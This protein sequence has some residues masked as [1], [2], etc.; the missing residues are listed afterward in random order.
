MDSIRDCL[1]LGPATS[2]QIQAATNL[3]QTAVS[4]RLRS[5][6]SSVV[7][8]KNG[9][10]PRYAMTRSA[11]GGSD[12]LPLYMVDAHGNNA[13]VA[14][15]RP[16]AHR[17]FLLEGLTGM[18]PVLLGDNGSGIFSNLPYFLYDLVPQGYIGRQIASELASQSDDFPKDPRLWSTNQIGR[19][20][21]SNGDDLPGNFKFGEQAHLRVR[22]RPT[23][24]TPEEYPRLADM[25]TDGCVP[26]SSAGG[27]QPKFTA[28]CADRAAHVIVKFSPNGDD[29]VARRW[30]DVMMTEHH[31]TE[32]I[33]A[34]G[35]PAAETRLTEQEGRLFLESQRFDR[36]G[37]YGR[38]SMISLQYVD[39]EFAGEGEGW[40]KS[41][42]ALRQ[43]GLVS[44]EHHSD[45]VALWCFGLLINNT[46]MHLG[47]LSLGIDGDVFRILPVYDM[48][49]MGF[50]PRNGEVRPFSFGPPNLRGNPE[51]EGVTIQAVEEM[52][53]S[54]W[55]RV[56]SDDR[57]SDEFRSFLQEGNPIDRI[58]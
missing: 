11:F 57:I 36:S 1:A 17:G 7:A 14:F 26:G 37:E 33:H 51:Y 25:A 28:F 55:S 53:R 27:E 43:R 12:R 46:D 38:L 16:L 58:C 13:A 39:A 18:P 20:L 15:V 2:R 48:C 52:A 41:M 24:I 22:R 3:S 47:N 4:R 42:H 29:P 9:R 40:H 30:R 6:G 44:G 23:P 10:S 5:M 49:S 19:Y 45:A 50:A 32:A 35:F 31:A 56:A 21:V 8:L 54:F 34:Q